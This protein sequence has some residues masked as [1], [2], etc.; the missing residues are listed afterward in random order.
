MNVKLRIA[1]YIMAT[2]IGIGGA[3]SGLSKG[4]AL[5]IIAAVAV[6]ME[7]LDARYRRTHGKN[8]DA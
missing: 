7:L 3:A 2:A 8:S 1:L 5:L 4:L 6:P